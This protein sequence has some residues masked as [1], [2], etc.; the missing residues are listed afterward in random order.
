M[1]YMWFDWR[2]KDPPLLSRYN[3]FEI[4]LNPEDK[5]NNIKESYQKP[6]SIKFNPIINTFRPCPKT[7]T[8][9]SFCVIAHLSS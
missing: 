8:F 1:L 3:L 4:I 7:N 9:M 2:G 5:N 6:F